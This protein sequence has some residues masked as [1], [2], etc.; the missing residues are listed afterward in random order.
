M[1][2]SP[3]NVDGLKETTLALP[4]TDTHVLMGIKADKEDKS[5]SIG[6]LKVNGYGGHVESY[7]SS[8]EVATH[9]ELLQESGITGIT[10]VKVGEMT[11]IFPK[12]PKNSQFVHIYAVL[13]WS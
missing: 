5:R 1:I 11:Y 3:R 6:H 13:K 2:I 12:K 4:M 10:Y 7:D 8:V 9:R